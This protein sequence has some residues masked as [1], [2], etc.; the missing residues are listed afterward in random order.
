MK[1]FLSKLKEFFTKL[2]QIAT[3]IIALYRIIK[4]VIERWEKS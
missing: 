3:P 1:K 2:A 4:E